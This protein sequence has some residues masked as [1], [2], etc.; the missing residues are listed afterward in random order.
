MEQKIIID[1]LDTARL[2]CPQCKRTKTL[3][4][5]EYKLIKRLTRVKYK[6]NCGHTYLAI[7]EKQSSPQ[8]DTM[9]AG[10]FISRGNLRCSGK[11]I[12]KRLNSKGIT[13]KT[14][15]EQKI[16]PGLD[17]MLEFVLDDAKQ[18]IVKKQV[19]VL[20]RNGRY[21]TAEFTCAEH[22]DNLGPYLFF[23]RLYV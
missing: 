5:S 22:Y 16:L 15:I 1:N 20:A 4:L 17:L 14:N 2:A 23:N 13:L 3:Q 21:L 19:R 9:L 18:S 12:I 7:L 10:T 8:K 11:M 6:C